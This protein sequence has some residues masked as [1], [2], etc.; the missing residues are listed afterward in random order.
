MALTV[1]PG[2]QFLIGSST[3]SSSFTW[4][5][6]GQTF[7]SGASPQ[8]GLFHFDGSL[9]NTA[10]VAPTTAI[11]QW[12]GP[13]KF[14]N[15]MAVST[16]GIVQ[17][18]AAGNLSFTNGTIEMWVAPQF[19]GN[20]VN[21][22]AHENTLLRYV[23]S[24]GDQLMVSESA[25]GVL[26]A[27]TQ[28]NGQY[29]GAGGSSITAWSA[30]QW[31]H[32]AFT[33]SIP[34][35]RYR[36]YIDGVLINEGDYAQSE[37]PASGG[38]I[39]L[40]S[41]P[42]G[43][44]SAYMI[45]E[46]RILNTEQTPQEI[47]SDVMRTAPFADN[48]VYETM[49]S[50]PAGAI[51]FQASNAS[52][53]S[54]GTAS[55]TVV[56][57]S[58][59]NPPSGL[60][61]SGSTSTPLTFTTS[62]ATACRYS[63]GSA[64][65]WA[66]MQP[67]DSSQVTTHSGTVSG[68]SSDP[69][70]TTNVY[71]AC[72]LN[73]AYTTALTYRSIAG[74]YGPYPRIGSIWNAGYILENTPAQASQIQLFLGAF[75]SP[76]QAAQIRSAN[77]NVLILP[78]INAMETVQGYPSVPS[79]YFLRDIYGNMI[80]DWPGD[81]VLNLTNP[82]VVQFMASYAQQTVAQGNFAF[83][84]MFFDNVITSISN[85]RD[86]YGNPVQIDIN[87]DGIADNG[88]AL[89]AAWSAGIYREIASFRQ[90]MPNALASGHMSATPPSPSALSALN[91]DALDFP[92]AN[93]REGTAAFNS[94]ASAYQ[95]WFVAGQSPVITMLES[96]P[97]NQIA[98]GYGFQPLTAALPSTVAFGQTFYPNMRFGLANT[99][100]NDGFSVYDF[101]DTAVNVDWWYDEYNFNLGT[102][103]GPATQI[104]LAPVSNMLA[105]GGF[106]NG[107]T[108]WALIN[109][110]PAGAQIAG[111]TSIVAEGNTSAHITVT[112]A[113]TASWQVSLEQAS[114]PLTAG[115]SYQLQFWA[116]A[117][118]PRNITVNEQGGAPNYAAYGPQTRVAITTNWALYTVSFVA[119]TTANDGRIQ[120]FIGD[121]T[122]NVWID[123]VVLSLAPSALYRRDFT[124]GSVLLN[125]T[126]TP[127]T[128][129]MGP[130]FQRFSG[131]QAPMY[132]Y[133]VD[134]TAPA[135]TTTTGSWSTVT[136][137]TGYSSTGGGET[138]N[139]P[140]YHAWNRTLHQI[141]GSG[142]AQWNLNIPADGTYTIQ[143]W[144]P[145]APN[146]S[147]FTGNAVYQIVAGGTVVYSTTLN[148]TG[149]SAGDQWHTIATVNLTAASNPVL[150]ISNAGSGLLNADAIY[151]TS[152][153]LYNNGAPASSVTLA[154]MDGILLQRQTPV[155][156]PTSALNYVVSTA[157]WQPEISP[158]S[159]VSL[160]G[161]GFGTTT[162]TVSAGSIV[163]N[164]LPTQLGGISATINGNQVAVNS[165]SPNQVV[166]VAPDD[167]TVGT[168]PV[169]LTVNGS[170]FSGSVTLQ[171]FA[172]ALFR[173]VSGGLAWSQAFH[174]NGAA[175]TPSAPANPGET[176]SLLATGLGATS[177][178][179]PAL[180]TVTG[181]APTAMPVTATIGGVAATVQYAAKVS[182]GVYQMSLTVPS[183]AAAGNQAIQV[184]IS[185]FSSPAGVF[186]PVN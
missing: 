96:S 130:G 74:P 32:I 170:T 103:L 89:D 113:G 14:G 100:M 59:V 18:P 120:F 12:F 169:Q 128:I 159:L 36:L 39:T 40:D 164:L 109:T 79:S 140:Y 61:P 62:Q 154:P 7:A 114:V 28:V 168:V 81:Y 151:V 64:A 60:L 78:S 160:V 20:S 116:R 57:L 172:P 27:G 184:G 136:Y 133:I 127:Q 30:W 70:V 38:S 82:A 43:N 35:K 91:G 68:L 122:G 162:E 147:G 156:A 126:T 66:S 55:F 121:A 183:S 175:V 1:S 13:G 182:P 8:L 41:D 124:N 155:A 111:D 165:I 45:D 93:V 115:V 19:A 163:G 145:A 29:Q 131:T 129:S 46:L 108:G 22:S 5:D 63:V 34:N 24:N 3:G 101:G 69:R 10:G 148:Q 94:L 161:S 52:G 2:S 90:L 99:L 181:W 134:D 110:P 152:A 171:K 105:N 179:T 174:A 65:A 141:G 49:N 112:T 95:S 119:T 51:G 88:P 85:L 138:V 166:L 50:L 23:A 42:W 92:P 137:D 4:T 15:S 25:A 176:I 75:I 146:A 135:F 178:A 173:T 72:D 180:Q 139:G 47:G 157:T 37:T 80:E 76:A 53:S 84:G 118:N 132:Q 117:D 106:E 104:G 97:P 17:Y 58:N 107:F 143:A 6:N 67:F 142:T 33:Y 16:G 87:G 54:C 9:A 83:D 21:Y 56:Q 177:P 153:A 86:M 77:P 149:A 73:P 11:G 44:S 150:Q 71:F 98:Y 26:Y 167:A 186:L 102:P 144:L 48:E 123:G 185:G 125:G 31:H 158:S